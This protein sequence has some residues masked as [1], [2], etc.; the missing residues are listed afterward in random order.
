MYGVLVPVSA[1]EPVGE[2]WQQDRIAAASRSGQVGHVAKPTL[3][4]G[5]NA[6]QGARTHDT[7]VELLRHRAQEI[8]A[9]VRG[10]GPSGGQDNFKL[11]VTQ[12]ERTH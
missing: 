2:G 12:S 9:K 6:V 11:G 4:L 7:A 8:I 1:D 5:D 3:H 10:D